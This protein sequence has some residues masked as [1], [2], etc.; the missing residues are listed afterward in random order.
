ML[1]FY[2]RPCWAQQKV[3]NVRLVDSGVVLS[4][5]VATHMGAN[6]KYLYGAI[7]RYGGVVTERLALHCDF[8]AVE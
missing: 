8:L 4:C 3:P 2:I 7:E 6:G 5:A 1:L